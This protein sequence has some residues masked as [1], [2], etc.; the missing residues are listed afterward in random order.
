MKTLVRWIIG[1]MAAFIGFGSSMAQ[2]KTVEADLAITQVNVISPPNPVER[3]QT[4]LVRDGKIIYIGPPIDYAA[5]R[6]IDGRGRYLMPGL[7]DVHVHLSERKVFANEAD[8]MHW[9]DM[10]LRG[11]LKDFIRYGFTS[12]LSVGDYWPAII[13]VRDRI[14]D[15]ELLGPNLYISGP[16]IAPPHGHGIGDNPACQAVHYCARSRTVAVDTVAEA[17][18]LVNLLAQSGV[19]GIK[20]SLQDP[21]TEKNSQG[22]AIPGETDFGR[23]KMDRINGQFSPGVLDA[24]IVEAHA[25][26]LLVRA[27]TGTATAG[28]EVI[29]A[30]ADGLVHGPGVADGLLSENTFD[31]VLDEARLRN[32][33]I[34]TTAAVGTTTIDLWGTERAVVDGTTGLV[35]FLKAKEVRQ[36]LAKGLRSSFDKGVVVAFGTDGIFMP[37]VLDPARLE[38]QTLYKNGL[39]PEEVL[40]ALTING[41]RFLRRENEIGSITVGKTADLIIVSGDPLQIEDFLDRVDVTI[42]GGKIVWAADSSLTLEH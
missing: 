20:L 41:A 8:Y 42:K 18:E 6:A 39:R 4:V 36:P 1:A 21:V 10:E 26:N 16:M 23:V 35:G 29:R 13:K 30:G 11:K 2:A 38:L 15:G 12:V 17:R 32:V 31:Q 3:N 19:D 27:H 5:T 40:S 14:R 37:R 33:P 22:T 7:I 28:L 9:V 25:R 34:T 24:L